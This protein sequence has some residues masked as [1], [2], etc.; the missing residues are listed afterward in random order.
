MK[1]TVQPLSKQDF[2]KTCR[3]MGL[4]VTM[5]R[6][7]IYNDLYATDS[8]PTAEE[9]YDR[10]KGKIPTLSLATIYKNLDVLAKHNLITKTRITGERARDD[11]NLSEH[12]HL[13]CKSCGM[14]QDVYN[15]DL[16]RLSLPKKIQDGFELS[17]Y[18][19]DFLGICKNC[20]S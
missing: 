14:I 11:A 6:L 4:S 18:R 19:I 1:T 20:K 7:A 13:V 8:H 17:S 9:I 12:H 5:Q 15:E 16:N 10:L 3:K 2:V